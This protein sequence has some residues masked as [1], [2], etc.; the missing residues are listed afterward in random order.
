MAEVLTA[1][2]INGEVLGAALRLGEHL[3]VLIENTHD[4]HGGGVE[5]ERLWLARVAAQPKASG[6]LSTAELQAMVGLPVGGTARSRSQQAKRKCSGKEVLH[7]FQPLCDY[8]A[9]G[10]RF[11]DVR[12]K[13]GAPWSAWGNKVGEWWDSIPMEHRA[14]HFCKHADRKHAHPVNLPVLYERDNEMDRSEFLEIINAC[15]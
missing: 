10:M 12:T 15:K 2:D 7:A 11:Q 5:R 14:F 8:Y 13:A 3:Y 9:R 6:R 1:Q 4:P